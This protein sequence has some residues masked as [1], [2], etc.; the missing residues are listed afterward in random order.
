MSTRDRGKRSEAT[1]WA[2]L[3][4]NSPRWAE[5]ETPL[6]RLSLSEVE[7]QKRPKE[8][9]SNDAAG[10]FVIDVGGISISNQLKGFQSELRKG[11]AM[12]EGCRGF[13]S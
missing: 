3:M 7:G 5:S 11:E 13:N 1:A 4:A 6:T 9:E 12:D 2:T 10:C 8:S